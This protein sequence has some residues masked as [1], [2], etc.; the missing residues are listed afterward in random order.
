MNRFRRILFSIIILIVLVACVP[1][2]AAGRETNVTVTFVAGGAVCGVY[3]IIY[4]TT[5]HTSDWRPDD[6]GTDAVISFASTGLKV[7]YPRIK[8]QTD[9]GTHYTPYI[10]IVAVRF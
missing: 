2:S 5:G 6:I 10:E 3:L 4:L 7:S 1:L 9:N 8:C